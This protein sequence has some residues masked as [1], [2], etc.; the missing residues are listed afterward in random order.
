MDF[1]LTNEQMEF[2]KAMREFAEKELAP[3]AMQRDLDGDFSGIYDILM[4]KWHLWGFW[5]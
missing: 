1:Q 3:G 5:A 4:K 2:Q